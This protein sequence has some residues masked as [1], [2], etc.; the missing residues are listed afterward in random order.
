MPRWNARSD[1]TEIIVQT[2]TEG[3]AARLA[4]DVAVVSHNAS[5]ELEFDPQAPSEGHASISVPCDGFKAHALTKP[6]S[7]KPSK[8]SSKDAAHIA[9]KTTHNLREALGAHI[10]ISVSKIDD[11]GGSAFRLRGGV[12]GDKVEVVCNAQ[13][14][15][16]DDAIEVQGTARLSLSALG[17]GPVKGPLG[18]LTVSDK[19]EVQFKTVLGQAS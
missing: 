7:G 18:A 17:I 8:I 13:A 19:I 10:Q 3:F 9:E 2:R 14:K 5:V 4:Y 12:A 11:L 16:N 15:V 1:A 6:G